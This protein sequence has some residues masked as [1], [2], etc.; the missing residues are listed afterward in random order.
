M[1]AHNPANR[2]PQAAQQLVDM[3]TNVLPGVT[4]PEGGETRIPS[5]YPANEAT[6]VNL[7]YQQME[8]LNAQKRYNEYL[9]EQDSEKLPNAFDLGPKRNLLH[10][11]GPSPLLWFIPLKSTTGD[12]WSW[13]PNPAWVRARQANGDG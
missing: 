12:G 2:V 11:F 8:R 9:D 5:S 13:E 6:P 4:R 3:H 10:L 1:H 7:S